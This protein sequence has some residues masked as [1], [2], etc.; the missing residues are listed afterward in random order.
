MT[1]QPST[2]PLGRGREVRDYGRDPKH[3]PKK[4]A[5]LDRIRTMRG[6]LSEKAKTL[7]NGI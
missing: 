4:K 3:T 5:T 2:M 6:Q 7:P 1:E